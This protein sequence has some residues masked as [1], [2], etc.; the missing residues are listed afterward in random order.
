MWLLEKSFV[1]S[2]EKKNL[3]VRKW[4]TYITLFIA[5]LTLAGD[6]VTVLYYFIDG[7]ELTTGFLLKICVVLVL[8]GLVFYYYISDIREKLTAKSRLVWLVASSFVILVS[9]SWGFFVLGSPRTQQLMKYDEQKVSD[10][11]TIDSFIQSYYQS[12]GGL[13]ANFAELTK[14]QPTVI[15]P[16]DQQT[17]QPYE[18]IL[19][20]QSAKAYQ[21]C[22]TFN[23]ASQTDS[24]TNIPVYPGENV[25]SNH[26]AGHY[27]FNEAIPVSMYP[28][29]PAVY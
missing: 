23:A 29:V 19:I 16:T 28:K 21:L 17:N 1:T 8:A 15:L 4:L 3:G 18:Y 22:A 9:I 27:C 14:Y 6:L 25:Y 13:P 11:Q 7:Q 2:P 12:T 24:R 5:G 26:P 20:G 10:L